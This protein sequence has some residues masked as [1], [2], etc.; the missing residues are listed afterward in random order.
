MPCCESNSSTKLMARLVGVCSKDQVSSFPTRQIPISI[1]E[2]LLIKLQF[3]D[4]FLL[5]RTCPINKKC[6]TY[7]TFVKTYQKL[8]PEELEVALSVPISQIKEYIPHCV[9]C[10]GCRTSI[11]TF[12][13]SLIEYHH[14]A[15]EPLLLDTGDFFTIT[16]CFRSNLENIYTLFYTYGSKLNP[17]IESIPKSK[18]SRRC[19]I[20]LL[21]K[22]KSISNWDIVWDLMDKECREEVTLIENNSLFQT[23]ENYLR[24]HKFCSEC[25]LKVSEA[26]ELLINNADETNCERNG[27]RPSLYAGLRSCTHDKH[28]HVDVD[29][30]FIGSL[31]SRAEP[32]IDGSQRERHAKTLDVAQEEVLTCI[33]IYLFDRLDKIYRTIRSEEQTCQLLFYILINCL[34]SNFETAVDRKQ[35]LSVALENLCEE[36]REVKQQKKRAKKKGRRQ[37]KQPEKD[38]KPTDT[39]D[40]KV[41]N[42]I[43]LPSIRRRT[44]SC[45][46]CLCFYCT[47]RSN[48]VSTIETSSPTITIIKSPSCPSLLQYASECPVPH[49][50]IREHRLP[51]SSSLET[52]FSSVS[53]RD[54]ACHEGNLEKQTVLCDDCPSSSSTS[55]I[56]CSSTRTDLGYSSGQDDALSSGPWECSN[57]TCD[58]CLMRCPLH[59][60]DETCCDLVSSNDDCS[61]IC[62]IHETRIECIKHRELFDIN[63]KHKLQFELSH[64]YPF[65]DMDLKRVW[66]NS[67]SLAAETSSYISDVDIAHFHHTNGDVKKTRAQLHE[68]FKVKFSEWYHQQAKLWTK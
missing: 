58:T 62:C 44:N 53:T 13:K 4:S 1:E 18:K 16:K 33:G 39:T 3:D 45:C 50:D 27:F 49:R 17:F 60:V 14:P 12:I 29:K 54:C 28:I 63:R 61:N 38:T 8:T 46:S 34:K 24:K 36:F 26:F 47:E 52:L 11:D 30:D 68:S 6:K 25:K 9:S 64:Q 35:D 15:L 31:I 55:C 67:T 56:R 10:I 22:T 48:S 19:N 2:N 66:D 37:S 41:S 42:E 59:E 57:V 20:H 21:E 23:L 7:E 5:L 51:Q 40:E 32:D 65:F 43:K